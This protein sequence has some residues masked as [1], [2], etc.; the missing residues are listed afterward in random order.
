MGKMKKPKV[1]IIFKKSV[2]EIYFV[3]QLERS[4]PAKKIIRKAKLKDFEDS[5]LAHYTTLRHVQNVLDRMDIRHCTCD[6]SRM[7]DFSPFDLIVTVGGD[8]TLLSASSMVKNQIVL[9]VNSNPSISVGRF[10][11]ATRDTFEQLLSSWLQGKAAVRSLNRMHL[12]RNKKATGIQVLNDVLICHRNPAAMSHYFITVGKKTEYQRSSGVWISTSAGSTGAT[13]SAGGRSLPLKSKK[14]VYQPRELYVKDKVA[15]KMTGDC[16]SGVTGVTLK[17]NMEEGC[18]YID[19]SRQSLPFGHG[20][21][22][23]VNN[24]KSPLQILDSDNYL[25]AHHL[26]RD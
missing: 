19:G 22:L 20:D 24:S 13:H 18:I 2:Y 6:R 7:I 25:E 14:I 10:C 5:H 12:T 26:R 4:S 23:T 11:S 1:L 15:Y 16:I 17:S 9:G 8:G 21:V 3:K